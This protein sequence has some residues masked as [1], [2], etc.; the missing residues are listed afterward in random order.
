LPLSTSFGEPRRALA[1]CLVLALGAAALAA[2]PPMPRAAALVVAAIALWST[3]ALAEHVTALV[4]FLLALV[5]GVAPAEVVLSG[6]YSEALWLIFAGLIVGVAVAKSGLAERVAGALASRA[7]ARY[8]GVIATVVL[9][10]IVLT[11]A[12]PSSMGR[13]VM[14]MP[15]A[16]ALGGRLGYA[17]GSKGRT[18]IALAAVLGA[19]LPSAGVLP[20]NL[21]NIVLTAS[22]EQL[23]GIRFSYAEYLLL[24]FPTLG[25]LKALAIVGLIAWLY[26]EAPARAAPPPARSPWSGEERAVALVLGVAM[27]L[28]ITDFMHGVSPAWVALGA[29]VVCMLPFVRLFPAEAFN[30]EISFVAVF[31]AAG[32]IGLGAVVAYS[33]FGE[34]IGEALTAIAPFSAQSALA[35]FS[36]LALVSTLTCLVTTTT[37]VPA[38]LT[39]LSGALAEA[40]G[41]PLKAVLLSQAVGFSN[42]IFPYEGAPLVFA[43]HYAGVPAR[44]V[45]ALLL[46]LAALTLIV[47]TPLTYFWWA[48]LG[49]VPA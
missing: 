35:N 18:G 36:L 13:V 33:G 2:L 34:A 20:S 12:M 8:P 42:P 3:G 40:S 10:G 17:P 44:A 41:L 43:L 29:A 37:G 31:H 38:V 28:W 5:A 26:A 45:V 27:A 4:F 6:F 49:Y 7:G 23:Y 21:P 24:A 30:R 15:I 11:F 39:P 16:L 19:Y 9:I 46:A 14:L 22:A 1:A 25:I 47:L 48:L 32:V